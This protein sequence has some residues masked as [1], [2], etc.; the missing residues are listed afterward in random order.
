VYRH[1]SPAGFALDLAARVGIQPVPRAADLTDLPLDEL[2]AVVLEQWRSSKLLPP[3]TPASIIKALFDV[4]SANGRAGTRYRPSASPRRAVLLQASVGTPKRQTC[5]RAARWRTL[6][7]EGLEIVEA[8][9]DH[10]TVMQS[11]HV[12]ALAAQLNAR[13]APAVAGV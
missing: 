2:L 5:A 7:G 4:Y 6:L 13:L 9:G 3:E 10:H 8:S 1:L 12:Q 11:P